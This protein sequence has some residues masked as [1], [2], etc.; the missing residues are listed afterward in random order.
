MA[1][2]A[3]RYNAGLVDWLERSV[4]PRVVS[5]MPPRLIWL[6]PCSQGTKPKGM[7][8]LR[9]VKVLHAQSSDPTAPSTAIELGDGMK[10]NFTLA[11]TSHETRDAFLRVW[12]N[13]V[14][15]EAVSSEF[16]AHFYDASVASAISK[17]L[18]GGRI[19]EYGQEFLSTGLGS[20]WPSTSSCGSECKDSAP[21][22]TFDPA[23]ASACSTPSSMHRAANSGFVTTRLPLRNPLKSPD[24]SSDDER[25]GAEEHPAGRES[26][27]PAGRKSERPAGRKSERPAGRQSERPAGRQSERPAGRKSERPAGRES[28]RPAGRES[29]RPAGR[30]SERAAASREGS[31]G[32]SP[33][34]SPRGKADGARLAGLF[35]TPASGARGAALTPD[36]SSVMGDSAAI[37]NVAA[38]L[39][40]FVG[41]A[42]S[43]SRS[44][45]AS[46]LPTP[47]SI[48]LHKKK[49]RTPLG[50]VITHD[51]RP[52]VLA[53][54]E[55]S[56][57]YFCT[58]RTSILRYPLQRCNSRCAPSSVPPP[59]ARWLWPSYLCTFCT[60][61][62]LL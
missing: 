45:S 32:S 20:V 16:R 37:A 41:C 29:E 48:S 35:A 50:M 40:S 43:S 34:P 8:N 21:G 15:V 46:L 59:L 3:R 11:F 6:L 51:A 31:L 39:A 10:H 38:G 42:S 23:S 9:D 13:V 19:L 36:I 44:P 7:I 2:I 1:Q 47:H 53:V 55:N 14:P 62:A 49:R 12:V 4:P 54:T 24:L 57:R 26:E 52:T 17:L 33:P 58:F 61:F 56:V 30:E 28:E 27:R 60:P 18:G 25:A 22:S 5:L